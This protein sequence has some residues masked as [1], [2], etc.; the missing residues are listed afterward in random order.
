MRA[1]AV[2]A[3]LG[4]LS[5]CESTRVAP[6]DGGV[7][8]GVPCSGSGVTKGPWV[9]A[10]SETHATMRWETCRAGTSAGVTLAPEADA[11]ASVAAQ[12]TETET[13]LPTEHVA[14]L[15][16]QATPDYAGAFFMHEASFDALAP[17]TCYDY[18]IDA[19]AARG[20]RF[21]TA[22]PSGAPVR[23]LAIGDTNVGL[24]ATT[25]NILSHVMPMAPDL[26]LHMGDI[27]YYDS[28][29]DTWQL[30]FD[31]MRPALSQVPFFPA[32]GNHESETPDEYADYTLRFFHG[33]GFGGNDE[34]Y[35]LESGGVHFYVLDT[36]DATDGTSA[37]AVWFAQQIA[38]DEQE[39]GYRMA[40][41]YFH[42]PF[43]TCGDT[44]DDPV[45]RQFFEPLFLAHKV[46]LVLQ[47]H[48]HGYERFDFGNITYVTTA[49]GGGAIGDVNANVS[50][51]YCD[52][53][54]VSGGF[55]HATVLDIGATSVKGTVVDDHG[56]VRDSFELAIP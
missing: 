16:P 8:A 23:V 25:S 21:C 41:V 14:Q 31:V 20:G 36:Q 7:E 40:I 1:A 51:S 37:Q 39:P 29:F 34:Y 42:K 10:V 55:F 19:D 46:P 38:Q 5:G 35:E 2:L 17:G 15:D 44:G 24:G 11:G 3:L 50:R 53:R 13:D 9:I 30:W 48:M 32:I 47:A 45:A 27:E 49:G 52:E 6:A 54:V 22:K 4:V 43:V 26:L 18:A 28:G 33:A 56:V 12:A